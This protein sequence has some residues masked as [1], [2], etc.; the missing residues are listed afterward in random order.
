MRL[1]LLLGCAAFALAVPLN[2]ALGV[3]LA[4]VEPPAARARPAPTRPDREL[5]GARVRALLGFSRTPPAAQSQASRPAPP[6]EARLL[7]TLC[8]SVPGLSVATLLLPTGRS[9]SA[10]EGE[11]V[12]GAQIVSIART[13]I[14]VRRDDQDEV[15]VVGQ[16]PGEAPRPQPA[17]TTDFTVSRSSIKDRLS[18]LLQLSSEVRVMPAYKDGVPV[19]FRLFA[20]R[21]DWAPGQLGVQSGD[22]IR[23]V[24]GQPLDSVQRVLTLTTLIDRGGEVDLELERE[25]RVIHQRY[26]LD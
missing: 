11:W 9:T 21:P 20:T 8:S 12:L 17:R 7:G 22:V 16:R 15:V 14:V 24:N 3:V 13:H 5:D 18:N 25:G 4:P 10:W 23:A 2:E 26:R 1:L 19:G 6:F